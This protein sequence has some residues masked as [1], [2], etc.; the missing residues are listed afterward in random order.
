MAIKMTTQTFIERSHKVHN[1]KYI[2]SHTQYGKN[3]KD[4]VVITCPLHGNFTKTPMNHLQGQGCQQC[5]SVSQS[6]SQQ[7]SYSQFVEKAREIHGNRYIYKETASK[8][9]VVCRVHGEISTSSSNHLQGKGCQTCGAIRAA[10]L[11]TNYYKD[12]VETLS[13]KYPHS[14]FYPHEGRITKTTKIPVLCT[15]H[16][17]V[18][19]ATINNQLQGHGCPLCGNSS[20]GSLRRNYQD[21][22]TTLYVLYIPALQV[23]KI[24]IT[25][26][27]V[28]VR[29]SGEKCQFEV[30]FKKE[31][32]NGIE[33]YDEEQRVL[34]ATK[35]Y[36]TNL[37][38]LS[39]G[40]TELRTVSPL[41]YIKGNS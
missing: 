19:Y 24:G 37:R 15:I 33:A 34:H 32:Q 13:A 16:E 36:A 29:Y 26:T 30:L 9:Q 25:S 7:L 18:F 6:K 14:R 27:S 31:Y 21:K 40:N 17:K 8:V 4:P 35:A 41:K 22:P 5:G 3:Q 38:P 23:Y 1:N 2:Y 12:I 10:R 11:R 28:K 20:K 39:S